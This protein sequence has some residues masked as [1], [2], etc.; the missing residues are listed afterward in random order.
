MT[1]IWRI[2]IL[3]VCNR[4]GSWI[5]PS[6]FLDLTVGPT[7]SQTPI[8]LYHFIEESI[9]MRFAV[10]F[11]KFDWKMTKIWCIT[12]GNFHDFVTPRAQRTS[13]RLVVVFLRVI[14][15]G[16]DHIQWSCRSLG[17]S[18]LYLALVVPLVTP[19]IM[20]AV[21][22]SFWTCTR[23]VWLNSFISEVPGVYVSSLG[24]IWKLVC[25]RKVIRYFRSIDYHARNWDSPP[26]S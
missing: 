1:S 9:E 19:S 17:F 8:F 25:E 5:Q 22:V 16:T 23:Y 24:V 20:A 14:L 3:F 10:I 7:A 21:A 6:V 2:S 15:V 13:S 11:T 18:A 12:K 4:T 26:Y